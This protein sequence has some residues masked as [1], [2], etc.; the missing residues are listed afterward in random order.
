MTT[1]AMPSRVVSRPRHASAG[2]TSEMRVPD[3]SFPGQE[4]L[5][6]PPPNR[7]PSSPRPLLDD[8]RAEIVGGEH[9]HA[10][11]VSEKP[12][13]VPHPG[14][15]DRERAKDKGRERRLDASH[16][17]DV[18]VAVADDPERLADRDVPLE[19]PSEVPL[20][21]PRRSKSIAMLQGAAPQNTESARAGFHPVDPLGQEHLELVFG[22]PDP[23]QRRAHEAP[24][25]VTV[26]LCHVKAGVIKSYPGAGDG[27]LGV[28]I[29]PLEALQF[30]VGGMD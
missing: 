19:Q 11:V 15:D 16:E 5:P 17:H 13:P 28:P 18:G 9:A 10:S 7:D 20:L 26:L 6:R 29:Q 4:Y 8:P 22:K 2:R 30:Q 21:G 3:T 25:G 12:R 24:D 1:S 27:E 23:A 14:T